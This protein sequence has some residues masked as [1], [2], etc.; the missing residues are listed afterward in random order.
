[1]IEEMPHGQNGWL[2][3]YIDLCDCVLECGSFNH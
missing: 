3:T 1:M 2:E